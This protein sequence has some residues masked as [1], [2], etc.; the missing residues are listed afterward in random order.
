[1]ALSKQALLLRVL[2][3]IDASG[4][5]Y[6]VLDDVHP[7]SIRIFKDNASRH[8]LRVFIWNCT[9]G[10]KGR[11][12]DE[13][14]IQK[15]SGI[16]NFPDALTLLLGWQEDYEVFAGFYLPGHVDQESSSPSIQVGRDSLRSARE[17]TFAVH[18]RGNAETV[19]AFRPAYLV[20]YALNADTLH[21]SDA[22]A[23]QA[24]ELLNRV[25]EVSEEDISRI[26]DRTRRAIVSKIKRKFREYDFRGR[27]LSAYRDRCAMCGVQLQLI[28]AA[29]ILP[30]AIDGSTD[31]TSNGVALCC[32]HHRAFD[33]NLVSFDEEYDIQISQ[34]A[35]KL[36]GQCDRV[37]GLDSFRDN[38]REALLL[39]AD[40]R[41]YPNPDFIRKSRSSKR[42]ID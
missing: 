8:D 22:A 35:T 25:D 39:P 29:H 17:H 32:L 27:V 20:D 11:S 6:L 7:F 41:D 30:V 24:Q 9:H 1:M 28:E 26:E 10:G 15:T 42:W 23:A 2:N 16:K 33:R 18:T 34:H 31:E 38:L 36:L 13:F 37:G 12:E 4:W 5:R 40:K 19:I 3:G 21:R 14:R